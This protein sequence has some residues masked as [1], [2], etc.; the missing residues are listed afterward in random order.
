[1]NYSEII[2][3][4]SKEMSLPVEVVDLAYKASFEFIRNTISALPLK[5]ELSE[6]AFNKLRCNFNLPSLGKLSC[7]Y[8]RYLGMKERFK[9]LNKLKEKY[10]D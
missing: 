2:D 10:E 7:T 6:E 1:M 3:I 8:D 4:V 9:Y 5:E